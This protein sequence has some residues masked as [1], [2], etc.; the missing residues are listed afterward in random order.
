MLEVSKLG[1]AQAALLKF[2]FPL[3]YNIMVINFVISVLIQ[4]FDAVRA[5]TKQQMTEVCPPCACQC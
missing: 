1:A 3:V 5:V 2:V 4:A